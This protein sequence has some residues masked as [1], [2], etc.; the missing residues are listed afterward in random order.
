MSREYAESRIKEALKKTGGNAVKARQQVIAWTYED[1]KLLH[2]LTKAHLSG[3]V[4]YNIERILSGRGASEETHIHEPKPS[5]KPSAAPK[6]EEN[7]GMQILKAVA[8]NSG[9][10]FGLEA[11]SGGSKK[12]TKVSQ[13]HLDA[14]QALTGKSK[15]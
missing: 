12:R 6:K 9:T 13:K 1:P 7:F 11:Y 10:E 8:G 3:I 4:A 15:T 14:I 2:A 5:K